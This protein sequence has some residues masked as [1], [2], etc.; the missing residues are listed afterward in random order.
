MES[1][2]TDEA[3]GAGEA[4]AQRRVRVDWRT[5]RPMLQRDDAFW[6]EHE[7]RR[8]QQGLG[9]RE[10]CAANGLALSTFRHHVN[11]KRRAN[12]K[13]SVARAPATKPAAFVPVSTSR[14]GAA[15]LVE[16]TLEGMTLRLSGEAAE[17]V[18]AGVV[19][20]LA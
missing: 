17:R 3:M 11:G 4:A 14:P 18:L 2:M 19:A 12:A 20:R 15:A 5:G 13:P 7:Q 8:L 9:V 16:I 1:A 6:R 10:Y